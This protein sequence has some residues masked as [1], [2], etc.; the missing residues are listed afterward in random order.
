MNHVVFLQYVGI[1][2]VMELASAESHKGADGDHMVNRVRKMDK[3]RDMEELTVD[4]AAIH[5]DP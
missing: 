1:T 3:W 4:S 2:L 5:Q